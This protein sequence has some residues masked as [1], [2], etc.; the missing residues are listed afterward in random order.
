MENFE[1]RDILRKEIKV[2]EK[3]EKK[4]SER[5]KIEDKIKSLFL[6]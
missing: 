1:K 3:G 2:F 4:K 6:L 5:L